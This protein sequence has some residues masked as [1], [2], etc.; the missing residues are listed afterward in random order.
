MT[1]LS[2]AQRQQI[3]RDMRRKRRLVSPAERRKAGW[4]LAR[5]A[6]AIE[7]L[8]RQ[9][10][11]ALFLSADGEI[12]TEPLL[13][14]LLERG[15]D[16]YLPV[17]H[18]LAHNRLWFCRYRAGD[19]LARNTY[20]IQ[21]PPIRGSQRAPVWSLSCVFTPLV[22]F[23]RQGH[24]LGMGGGYYDRTFARIGLH[25]THAPLTGLAYAFQEVAALPAEAWDV[26]L[27]HIVTERTVIRADDRQAP[28]PAASSLD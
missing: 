9:R 25:K 20:G 15:C 2:T 27:R 3:R 11:V 6:S 8:G 22:A 14:R 19:R 26:P 17:L 13:Q 24:R 7:I 5:R 23:D 4:Q 28:S 18:P 1:P 16:V 21:E 10:R 12:P